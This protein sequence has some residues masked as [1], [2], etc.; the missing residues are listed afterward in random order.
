M[1]RCTSFLFLLGAATLGA[2]HAQPPKDLFTWEA[3]PALP[4]PAK[5]RFA[6]QHNGA[7]IVAGGAYNPGGRAAPASWPETVFVLP[8]DAQAWLPAGKLARPRAFGASVSTHAGVVL[9]GGADFESTSSEVLLL[10]WNGESLERRALPDLPEARAILSAAFMAGRIY[11][12][13]G[14]SD[15]KTAE[16][17]SNFWSLD[18]ESDAAWTVHDTWP[19]PARA[20][21][22]MAA[23]SGSILLFGGLTDAPEA[24]SAGRARYLQDGYRFTPRTERAWESLAPAPWPLAA[25]AATAYGQSYIFVFGRPSEGSLEADRDSQQGLVLTGEVLAYH[26][27]T[28]TWVVRGT[29]PDESTYS[30]AFLRNGEVLLSGEET[31]YT[32]TLSASRRSFG[33][34]NTTIV[35]VY[36]IALIAMGIYF[37]R[38]ESNMDDFFL[39]GHRVPWWA[40]GLSI[41]G[42]Q[43]SAI[44]YLAIPAR[45]YMTDWVYVW[46]NVGIVLIAPYLT[47]LI[48]PHYRRGT[49]VT[50]YEYLEQRFNLAARL[51]GASVFLLFQIGRVGIVLFLPAIAL[52]AVTGINV[53]FCILAM[54]LFSMVYTTLGGFE[55]VIWTD[56]V[57]VFVLSAG[58]IVALITIVT[59][60][61]GGVNELFSVAN[62]AGKFHAFNWTWDVTTTA[63]WVCLI[64][65]VFAVAYPYSADQ[66][67]V[68]RYLATAS[69]KDARRAIWTNAILA[70]P[71]TL[72]F[73]TMGT[74][75]Y[76]FFRSRP[77]FLDPTLQNDAI[78]ALFIVDHLPVGV[79]GLVIAA[80]FAAAM[81]SLDSS[82]N[83]VAAVIVRDFYGRFRSEFS[84]KHGLFVARLVTCIF[85]VLGTASALFMAAQDI[86]SLFEQYNRILGLTGGGLAGLLALGMLTKRANSTGALAGGAN[87][88][89]RRLLGQQLHRR[90]PLSLCGRRVR[91]VLHR[92]LR[93][94]HSRWPAPGRE[95]AVSDNVLPESRRGVY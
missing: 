83:S 42:T 50:A 23:Q 94:E 81:S 9:L 48:L 35:I 57:Q 37:S 21:A 16:P 24:D 41:F 91:H 66:T 28:E 4:Q 95:V 88:R 39:A 61:D 11:A 29:T 30:N 92:R 53:Y 27:I 75:L 56:V 49:F 13:G 22:I 1:K 82:M 25:A 71:A 68:Q 44:T 87:Q 90:P 52:N 6:G 15:L 80:I 74:A 40:I 55:V 7:L 17:Q 20:S 33:T 36:F 38:R 26:T 45:A 10:S 59:Q 60:L 73:F 19:G 89:G 78:F 46:A 51:Y 14:V 58:V 5:G 47:L 62:D 93:G 43:L 67:I 79:S 65:N 84:E 2:A 34:V 76:V 70:I 32:A 54:G 18:I 85:G 86:P 77:E 31:P 8:P 63:V 72:L 64:G 69:E 12:A 3:L